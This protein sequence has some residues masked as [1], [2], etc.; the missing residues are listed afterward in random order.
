M[1]KP[2]LAATAAFLLPLAPAA[3]GTP[4]T[5]KMTCPIGGAAFSFTTTAS[6]TIWGERPDG[7]PYG[8]WEF[9][10]ALPEC[11]DNGLVLYKDYDAAEVAKLEPLI[12]G[13]A[14]QALRKD[15]PYYRAYWLMTQM[16]VPAEARL[17]ALQRAAWQ[18]DGEPERRARYLAEFAE[19]SAKL[20]AEPN[21]LNWIGM[22]G[23][24]INALRELGRFDEAKARLAKLPLASLAVAEPE[25]EDKSPAAAQARTRR[26]WAAWF[27]TMNKLI[28]AS[29]ASTEP[30]ELLPRRVWS[31]RCLAKTGLSDRQQA[32]CT[33]QAAAVEEIRSAKAKAD[34]ELKALSESRDKSGR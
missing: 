12:A 3:A 15:V 13:Q 22:E 32:F 2:L 18:A 21:D 6:H 1:R 20:P 25:G 16:E 30:F 8:S 28:A 34:A 4:V 27:E 14:Y 33:A 7:K 26:H 11:P 24:A 23:R 9:P 17:L 5:Q 31:E 10:L 19:E 29:D